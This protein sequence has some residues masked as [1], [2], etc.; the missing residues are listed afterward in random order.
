MGAK[1]KKT[2]Y[3]GRFGSKAGVRVRKRLN[4]I[5]GLQRKRQICPYCNRPGA[6]RKVVGIW[7]CTKCGKTFAGHAYIME[8]QV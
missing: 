7:H 8:R 5:E 4:S 3:A 6:E 1:T 2:R